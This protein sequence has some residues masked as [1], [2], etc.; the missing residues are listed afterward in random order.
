[1]LYGSAR[2]LGSA[3]SYRRSRHVLAFASVPLA[4]SLVFA[5]TGRDV[6]AW[7]VLAF[8]AWSAALLVVGVRAV[9][10]W[11]WL[12]AGTA[13]ALPVAA[14]A[15]LLALKTEAV[16]LTGQASDSETPPSTRSTWP[17]KNDASSLARKR[18]V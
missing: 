4:L 9:H 11:T 13:A 5:P 15:A 2:A 18:N 14:A 17:V 10:G 8:V 16:P 7:I 1:V 12:R 3:G 6:F